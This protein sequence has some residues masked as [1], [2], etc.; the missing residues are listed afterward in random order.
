MAAAISL[1]AAVRDVEVV[2]ELEF[3]GDMGVVEAEAEETATRDDNS[4]DAL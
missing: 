3:G 1:P 2:V 4:D